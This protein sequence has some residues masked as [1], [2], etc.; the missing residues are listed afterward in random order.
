MSVVQIIPFETKWSADFARLNYEWIARYFTIEKHDREILDNPQKWVIEPGG[1]IF[2]AVDDG[3][4]A[5]TVALIP[6]SEGVLELTKMAVSPAFQG[7]G[8]A[9]LLMQQ[10]IDHA[11]DLGTQ[12]IF[13]E[14]HSSLTAALSLYK[15][16]GFVETPGDPESQYAR[17][18]VRMEYTLALQERADC[19]GLTT[20][21]SQP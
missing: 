9:S 13:L 15:K 20:T 17:A 6:A 1:Q 3:T 12:T 14:T 19:P 4:A 11:Q 16:F 21:K 10:C 2:M 18:D 7:R 8:I 5:G